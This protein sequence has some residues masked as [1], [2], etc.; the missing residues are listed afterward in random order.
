[1]ISLPSSL[2]QQLNQVTSQRP[3]IQK[4]LELQNSIEKLIWT[5]NMPLE[6][7]I[8]KVMKLDEVFIYKLYSV[9]I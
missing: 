8:D 1:M 6:Q 3:F 5:F 2:L 9:D 7:L 4:Y